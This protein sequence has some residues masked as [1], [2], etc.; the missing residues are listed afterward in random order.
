[1]KHRLDRSAGVSLALNV[2]HKHM[3]VA[4][5]RAC[6]ALRGGTPAIQ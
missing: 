4:K 2:Q 5:V 3:D 6:G 1:M